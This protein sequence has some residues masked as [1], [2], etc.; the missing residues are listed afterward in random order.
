MK[1]KLYFLIAFI[2]LV[3]IAICVWK[4]IEPS[5]YVRQSQSGNAA[6]RARAPIQL[7]R[8]GS[9]NTIESLATLLNDP[10]LN[11]RYSAAEAL[12]RIGSAGAKKH[13]AD[14]VGREVPILIQALEFDTPPG[15]Y[16]AAKAIAWIGPPAQ[17]A[18]PALIKVFVNNNG[19]VANAAAW[20]LGNIGPEARD[21]IPALKARLGDEFLST[22]IQGALLKITK[23]DR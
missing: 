9:V 17:A 2:S 6:L 23:N 1:R 12:Q 10:I 21:A 13:V 18:V 15:K 11:V 3:G 7:G 19:D 5:Y 8:I 20:A 14:Y 22:T 16:E 4:V